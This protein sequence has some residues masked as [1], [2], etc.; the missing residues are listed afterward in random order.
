MIECFFY[1][2]PKI[3]NFIMTIGIIFYICPVATI[4][5]ASAYVCSYR[6][7]LSKKSNDLLAVKLKFTDMSGG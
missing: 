2:L 5:I 7:Y 3:V 6:F 4:V 1:Q